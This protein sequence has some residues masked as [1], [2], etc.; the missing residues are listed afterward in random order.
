MQATL[1]KGGGP[2]S[3]KELYAG[4]IKTA[5]EAVAVIRQGAHVF[6]GSGAASPQC[7]IEAMAARADELMDTEIV[8]LLTLGTAPYVEERFRHRV[9][10]NAFFVGSNV[11]EAVAEGR[12]DYTPI[13]LSELPALFRSGRYRLDVALIQVTPPDSYGFCSLG[14]SV[15]IVKAAAESATVVIAQVNPRMPRTLGDSFIHVKQIAAL[16]EHEAPIAEFRYT[17]PDEVARRIAR[18]IVTLIEDGATLQLGIG[19][20]PAAVLEHLGRERTKKDLGI[21]T[22]VLTDDVI[23]A[24][25]AGVVTNARKSLY[26]G[27]A[28]CS[29]CIGTQRLYDYVNQ[30]PF[31]DFRPSD[32]V[33]DPFVIAQNE[34]MV[35]INAALEVDL[36]GQVCSDSLG[37]RFY[38]GIGGQVDF[39]RG[40]ARS[41]GGKPIIALPATAD[42]GKRS[43][44]VSHLSEGAGV[45]TTRG[46]VHYVVTEYGVADLYGRNTRERALAMIQI[47]HPDFREQL[48]AEAKARHYAFVD[49]LPPLGVYPSELEA[50]VPFDGV[51]ILFRPIK[52]TDE[53]M[54]QD[55]FY[56]LS[57]ESIYYRFFSGI[58]YMPHAQAQRY[59]V[60]DYQRE[61]AIVGVLRENGREEIV[62]VARYVVDP[63][64]NLAE[65]AFLVRDDW[66]GKGIG[67]W[68]QEQLMEIAKSRGVAGFTGRVLP[69]NAR[70]LH[71]VH[72]SGL[73]V[74]S[75][76]EDGLYAFTCRF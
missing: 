23:N 60:I 3:W 25:E 76:M 37:Y 18:Q 17:Q 65:A 50:S 30:N 57:K 54:M 28:V 5:Q 52:P 38:S 15:D 64:T 44:I 33:N 41:A 6:I 32:Y 24:I 9:R 4:K 36:T 61:M 2:V 53:P 67:T 40:A 56:A 35:A 8:H 71:L 20:I 47:A 27:K 73:T 59:T 69:E 51:E 16:V 55:L 31:F 21:H 74:E 13:F 45:V 39:I 26:P 62:A 63:A 7:L 10:H 19:A 22:E 70:V 75:S 72:K 68:L 12:A 46:D 11:R 29:F 14:V 42:D 34:R 58:S 1:V 66:Q 48:L 43:R 49:Q